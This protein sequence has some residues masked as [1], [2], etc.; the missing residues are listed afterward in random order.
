[1]YVLSNRI[2]GLVL[3]N[4]TTG[5]EV[6]PERVLHDEFT[7][8]NPHNYM[9]VLAFQT[10]TGCLSVGRLTRLSSIEY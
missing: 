9:Y 6:E 4:W 8:R 5:L 3:P 7:L 1:M 2:N 10:M